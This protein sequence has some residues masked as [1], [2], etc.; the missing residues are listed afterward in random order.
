[1][2]VVNRKRL[3]AAHNRWLRIILQVSWCD[4]ITNKRTRKRKVQEEMESIIMKRRLRWLSKVWRMD[5]ERRAN[6]VFGS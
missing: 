1:M 2:T 4:K 5:K 6:H 3:G